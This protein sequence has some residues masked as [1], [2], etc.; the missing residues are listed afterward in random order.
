LLVH[1]VKAFE[2]VQSIQYLRAVA[3]LSVAGY[4]A[5]YKAGDPAAFHV[6]NA[7]VDIFFVISGFVM[8][9]I[10]VADERAVST[11]LGRRIARIVPLY[12]AVTFFYVAIALVAPALYT[13]PTLDWSEVL[14][15]LFFIPY[16]SPD[17]MIFPIVAPGWTLDMEMYFYL[18][19]AA[20]LFAP[21]KWRLATVTGLLAAAVALRQ[22]MPHPWTAAQEMY[23]R[24]T[25]LEFLA[26]VW[27]GWAW[28][29][30]LVRGFAPGVA[31]LLA[32]F[33]CLAI[34][35]LT[36]FD[37]GSSRTIYWGG[38]AL[39][40]VLGALAVEASGRLPS[41]PLAERLGDASYSIYL[42]HTLF[43]AV[44]A[45]LLTVGPFALILP[46]LAR[47][48]VG[49]PLALFLI[50]VGP[51]CAASM[52]THRLFEVP[53]ARLLRRLG[54]RL[55]GAGRRALAARPQESG[56]G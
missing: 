10:T 19:F 43:L 38:P 6:G 55:S 24:W 28:R 1:E 13:W 14:K 8:W 36:G 42:F 25:L 32:G 37:P 54:A 53:A 51:L 18:I 40:M 29:K 34:Q 16:Y 46:A 41:L 2:R 31:L 39:F 27:A 45:K 49:T 30:G 17:G 35:P 12:W 20:A 44:A 33:A 5:G 50:T 48:H 11:F 3:A 9:N 21:A 56:L 22:V 7:G 15:S 52:L 47:L 23:T 4:H 26:G